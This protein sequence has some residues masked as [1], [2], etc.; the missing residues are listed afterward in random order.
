MK[1][2]VRLLCAVLA[3]ILA[4]SVS[5][6]S[7]RAVHVSVTVDGV[8]VVYTAETGTPFSGWNGSVM[9]PVAKTMA[10][11]GA[12]LSED[13][14]TGA[15]V[16]Q[17]GTK[18]VRLTP[19]S[20]VIIVNGT[21]V[22]APDAP[23]VSGGIL[24]APA[25]E[26]VR[27]LGGVCAYTNCTLAITTQSADSAMVRMERAPVLDW[28]SQMSFYREANEKRQAGD[29]TAA[30]ARYEQCVPGFAG[31]DVNLGM[32]FQFLG[33]CCARTGAYDK[34]AAAYA[35]AAL[36]WT[37]SG[38]SHH[39]S[40]SRACAESLRPE[41]S[42]YLKTDDPAL[43]RET[44][45]GVNYEPEHGTVLGYAAKSFLDN[46]PYA[47]LA[48][49]PAGMWLIYYRWGVSSLEEKLANVPDNV[50]VEL[51]VEP[52]EGVESV[53]DADVIRFARLLHTC[54]KQVMVR[55]A[56]EMNDPSVPWFRNRQ[57]Y[58]QTYK[59]GYIRFALLM[60][61]YA[62]GVPLIWSPNFFPSETASRFYPGDEY[63]DYVGVSSYISSYA[64]TDAER[65]SGL[66]A[67]GTGRRLQRWSRQIDFLYHCY[68][69]RKPILISEGAAAWTDR[70]TGED[71]V[72]LAAQ[73]IRDFYTYLPIRYPNLK[74]AVCFNINPD[75]AK[76]MMTDNAETLAA[77]NEAVSDA[78][79]LSG[80]QESAPYWYVPTDTF[81]VRQ[82]VPNTPQQLCAYANFG[83]NS[84]IAAVRYEINGQ[85]VGTAAQ[86]P[87]T[88]DCDFSRWYGSVKLRASLLDASG[89][90]L[91]SRLF[92]LTVGGMPDVDS[93][94]YYA[95]PVGW[96]V[97]NGIATGITPTAFAPEAPCT[98][99]QVVT[100]LW[101]AAGC[102]EP[103]SGV[104]PFTDV[105]EGDYYYSAV[106]WAAEN[107][108]TRGTSDTAFSPALTCTR[109]QSVTFLYRA[110]GSPAVSGGA[111]PF[112]DVPDD[113]YYRTP[114][115]WALER[116]I[117]SGTTAATFSPDALCTRGQ[118][119]TFLYR[120]Q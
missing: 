78:R 75:N 94:A 92:P 108:I 103:V 99:G 36:Y 41:I 55:Y 64:F 34:A 74:Y 33:E 68:G 93:A 42:L 58:P 89:S 20:S 39:A 27:G 19:G 15:Y 29:Y 57:D 109:G 60:R 5:A 16:V 81:N 70:S 31:D 86:A 67:L 85:V 25:A 14:D 105:H 11:C 84:R 38:N 2:T 61:S 96:A 40:V 79:Y 98:R 80:A 46:D 52:H 28:G 3:L 24:Y 26:L 18:Q 30:A 47:A 112:T 17:L 118:I 77:Y 50:V 4:L 71:A 113:A 6:P 88:I 45:H 1:S 101:R 49:K 44:T 8:P 23:V 69:Y 82:P 117:T 43:S 54:G 111:L 119:V 65:K 91:A 48:A 35:R 32:C 53:K 63:V 76:F 115:V 97:E 114:V 120:A 13:A 100:F 87:Y 102:P 9:L 116:G 56:N 95:L 73:Q 90:V 106:L 37:R 22:E 72:P 107:G 83:D 59:A 62:P 12:Y 104:N 51:A 10:D 21:P 7:S 66:D 110:A